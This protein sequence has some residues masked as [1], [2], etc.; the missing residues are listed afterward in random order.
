MRRLQS[1]PFEIAEVK[2]KLSRTHLKIGDNGDN[3]TDL[4][5]W[6]F[7]KQFKGYYLVMTVVKAM[8]SLRRIN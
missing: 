8:V 3:Q 4:D 6:F 2:K 1:V 5:V 7:V